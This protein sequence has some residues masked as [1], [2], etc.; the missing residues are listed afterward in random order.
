M[1][2]AGA[3]IYTQAPSYIIASYLAGDYLQA[4][5]NIIVPAA[6]MVWQQNSLIIM[7]EWEFRFFFY[8]VICIWWTF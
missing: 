2:A 7:P 5:H 4:L 8:D 1:N 6:P 3:M